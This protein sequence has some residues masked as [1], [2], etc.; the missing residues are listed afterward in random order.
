MDSLE[1]VLS[2][3]GKVCE[4]ALVVHD[5]Y[6]YPILGQTSRAICYG[7]ELHHT[8][9]KVWLKNLK[10]QQWEI[11]LGSQLVCWASPCQHCTL[12]GNLRNSLTVSKERLK[13]SRR[14]QKTFMLF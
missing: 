14:C 2:A 1:E 8:K 9:N 10:L 11:Q 3:R 6:F 13:L 12:L 7:T 5:P 4:D